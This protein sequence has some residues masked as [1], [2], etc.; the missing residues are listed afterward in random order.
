ME[1]AEQMTFDDFKQK[2]K[3]GFRNSK[4]TPEKL[5]AKLDP[6]LTEPVN[7]TCKLL[8]MSKSAFTSMCVR[9]YLADAERNVLLN[10]TKEELIEMLLKGGE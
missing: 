9:M 4:G 8:N 6:E 5:T 3:S 7:R 1:L 10:K 2:R